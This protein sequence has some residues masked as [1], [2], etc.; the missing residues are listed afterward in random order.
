MWRRGN[1][2]FALPAGQ[3]KC[4]ARFTRESRFFPSPHSLCVRFWQG[5]GHR[6]ERG[7]LGSGRRV[8]GLS[9]GLVFPSQES[10]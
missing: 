8:G 3:A 6:S 9:Q 5:A 1:G 7:N 10:G 4:L 2:P